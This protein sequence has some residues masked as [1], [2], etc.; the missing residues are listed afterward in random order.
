[1]TLNENDDISSQHEEIDSKLFYFL[2]RRLHVNEREFGG[3][4]G[5]FTPLKVKEY[6]FE[7]Y[8]TYG[9]NG[10]DSKKTMER[11]IIEMLY[12]NDIIKYLY[13]MNER[14]P[15]RVKIIKTIRK[16]IKFMLSDQK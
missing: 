5:D 6:S 11:K 12:E 1:M 10:Y 14:D 16:F 8:P 7:G 3:N 9:F 15:K 4:W 13:D 2:I